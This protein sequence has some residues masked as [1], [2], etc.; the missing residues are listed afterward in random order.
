MS[1]YMLKAS[2]EKET[3]KKEDINESKYEVINIQ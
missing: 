2:K 3:R 1:N